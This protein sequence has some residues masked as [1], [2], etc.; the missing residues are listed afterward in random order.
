MTHKQRAEKTK[1]LFVPHMD[2]SFSEMLDIAIAI[3]E[4]R[5]Y[6]PVFLIHW[7]GHARSVMAC[8][9]NGVEFRLFGVSTQNGLPSNDSKNIEGG[10]DINDV[11]SD[12]LAGKNSKMKSFLARMK[13]I[14]FRP[15]L[16]QFVTYVLRFSRIRLSAKALL[17][18]IKPVALVLMGDRHVGVETALVRVANE[19]AIPS[20]IVPFGLSETGGLVKYRISQPD[21]KKNYGMKKRVNQVIARRKPLWSLDYFDTN[22]LWNIAPWMV[23]AEIVGIMP[24]IPWSLGGGGAWRMAVENEYHKNNFIVQKVPHQ[25][26]VVV[27]KPRYDQ[28]AQIWMNQAE[29]KSH[30][31]SALNID[32]SKPLLVCAVPQMAEHEFLTW[33]EHWKEMEFLFESFSQLK[34]EVNTILSLHPKSDFAKY[35]PRA[36]KFGLPIAKKLP[37]DQL[38]PVCDGFVATYSSTV[39]LAIAAQKPTIVIDFYGFNIDLFSDVKGIEVVKHHEQFA[40]TLRRLFSDHDY[41]NQLVEGQ[42]QAAKTWARFDGKATERILNLIDD[43]VAQGK[44][45][46]KLQKREQRKALPSWSQ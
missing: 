15:F 3:K 6:S 27:G 42:T 37:Y 9:K 17:H 32:A 44:E 31:C 46:R 11:S 38:I 34:P 23:A 26:M 13:S 28:A 4:K 10:S 33:P 1:I 35:L 20:L 19:M 24:R 18:E 25:K 16:V 22:L 39:S 36:Q 43:L 8:K 29:H 2:S 45:I 5:K 14:I 30:I 21:W 40:P 12:G 7:A 41:Y